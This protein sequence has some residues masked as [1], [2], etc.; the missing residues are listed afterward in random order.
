MK[1]AKFEMC[2]VSSFNFNC[3]RFYNFLVEYIIF[4][5]F[6]YCFFLIDSFLL[7]RFNFFLFRL[8]KHSCRRS[9]SIRRWWSSSR[10]RNLTILPRKAEILAFNFSL[11]SSNY[12]ASYS[13]AKCSKYFK[14]Q[15]QL[16]FIW[17]IKT[18]LNYK[19]YKR[20]NSLN[21]W[22]SSDLKEFISNYYF[23]L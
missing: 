18:S 8:F 14:V 20:R 5:V 6:I 2:R 23:S 21:L 19:S 12:K 4:L 15:S 17:N 3:R 1:T 7:P 22:E 9:F 13:L 16:L 10:W 11:Y